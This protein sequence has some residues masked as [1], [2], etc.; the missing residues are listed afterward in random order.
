VKTTRL[1]QHS[2]EG[3]EMKVVLTGGGTAG[4]AFPAINVGLELKKE[5]GVS[6]YYFGNNKKIERTIA[7]KHD[8]PFYSV[9]SFGFQGNWWEKSVLFGLKNAKGVTDSIRHLKKIKP[10]FVFATGGF[11]TAPVLLAAQMLHIPFVIHEQNS[12]LGKVNRLF[13]KNATMRF[14]SFPIHSREGYFWSGNPVRYNE[15]LKKNGKNLVVLGGSGGSERLNEEALIFAEKHPDIPLIVQTGERFYQKAKEKAEKNQLK[16][17][18]LIPYTHDM[19]KELYEK[20]AVLVCRSGSGTLFEV[21]NL[22]IPSIMV[23][24]PFAAEDHQ[25]KNALFFAQTGAGTLVEEDMFFSEN[26]EEAIVD[27]WES[28]L[29][30][31]EMKKELDKLSNRTCAKDIVQWLSGKWE[32]LK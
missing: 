19:K 13:E 3:E 12:K 5:K 18:K 2:K 27:I 7:E 21:A 32:E 23:P 29:K 9:S 28:S 6:L 1:F 17:V 31:K 15:K 4:H 16:N 11:V 10:D 14:F 24:Y 20:A 30:R 22:T 26:L 8:I 25:K